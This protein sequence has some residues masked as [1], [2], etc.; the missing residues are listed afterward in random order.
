MRLIKRLKSFAWL[1]VVSAFLM[2]TILTSC[3]K[4]TEAAE[5]ESTEHPAEEA[6]TDEHPKAEAEHPKAE[7]DTT[8]VE[9]Q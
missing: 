8:K 3:G 6:G 4:A 2:S 9:E 7:S 5:E 1:F